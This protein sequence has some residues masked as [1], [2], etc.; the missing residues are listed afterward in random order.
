MMRLNVVALACKA[1]QLINSGNPIAVDSA[2]IQ[3]DI[4][5]L[6]CLLITKKEQ[7]IARSRRR[8][9]GTCCRCRHISAGGLQETLLVRS[10]PLQQR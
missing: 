2:A 5:V 6:G 1:Q 8:S 9:C 3:T 10:A 4:S 7:E